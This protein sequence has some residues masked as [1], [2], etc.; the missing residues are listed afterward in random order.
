MSDAK[1]HKAQLKWPPF[2]RRG[3]LATASQTLSA[4][5]ATSM[6]RP[7]WAAASDTA[8]PLAMDE[9]APGVFVHAGQHALFAPDNGG[10]ISNTGFIIGNKAVAVIDTSGSYRI[11]KRLKAAIRHRTDRPIEYVINT[12]MHPD[13]VF[14]NAAFEDAET[15]IVAHHKMARGLSARAERY[16][17]I[18]KELMGDAAFEGTQIA[19]PKL[20]VQEP[21]TLDIGDRSL[22]LTPRQTAHTDNDLTIFD[23]TTET[24]F[25]G[26]LIF[27]G[28]TPTNDG[29]ILGWSTA[30][31]QLDAEKPTRIVP[32]HGPTSLPTADA[33]TPMKRYIDAVTTGVREAIASGK[34]LGEAVE[35]VAWDQKGDWKLFSE[36]HGRNVSAAYAELEW[37]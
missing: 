32:G 8:S 22:S 20:S 34:T 21:M 23:E 19:L 15:T 27:S 30:L 31:S 6:L 10:D 36:Y 11:G 18:N 7:H 4:V 3:F 26:D 2:T 28:H 14:G 25:A 9:V 24:L 5:A 12:H 1:R 29:S 13:H 33:L 17:A 37:E 16:M 35:T